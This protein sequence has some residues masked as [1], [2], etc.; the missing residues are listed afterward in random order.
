MD[1]NPTPAEARC[2]LE[3]LSWFVDNEGSL[4]DPETEVQ[5]AVD[6]LEWYYSE[7]TGG[8]GWRQP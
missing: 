8:E 5:E 4:H 3:V 1:R 7:S 6:W 2:A